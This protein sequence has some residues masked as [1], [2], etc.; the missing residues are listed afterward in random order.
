MAALLVAVLLAGPI[1][2]DLKQTYEKAVVGGD[3]KEARAAVLAM[4]DLKDARVLPFLQRE[5][6]MANEEVHQRL[7]FRA[8]A[9]TPFRD[10]EEFL[11]EHLGSPNP[12]FRATALEAIA[13]LDPD[14]ARARAAILLQL[15]DDRRVRRTAAEVLASLATPEALRTLV[16]TARD[17]SA[18]EQAMV[19]SLLRGRPT[20]QLRG[21]VPLAHHPDPEVRVVALLVLS[22]RPDF[23][24]VLEEFRDDKDPRVRLVALTGLARHAGDGRT[25]A[26]AAILAKAK[27]FDE[28]WEL[29][30]LVNRGGLQDAALTDS[31]VKAARSGLKPLRAKAA[32]AA[33]TAGGAAAVPFLKSLLAEDKPWQLPIGAARGLAATRAPEAM[34]VLIDALSKTTGRLQHE[35]SLALE[36]LT[37]QPFGLNAVVWERWWRE[38]GAG[39]QI[40]DVA[41]ALWEA[42]RSN[43]RYAFYGIEL[44]TDA[45]AFV[46]DISG[47][48]KGDRIE[49]LK[50][51][52]KI[53]VT[54]FPP[55]GKF[56]LVF[57]N[58]HAFAWAKRLVPAT[59]RNKKRALGLIQGLEANGATNIWDALGAALADKNVDTVVLLTDGMPTA[60]KDPKMRNINAIAVEFLNRNRKR[61]VL[62]HVVSIGQSSPQL[63]AMARLSGGTYTEK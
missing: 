21:V 12:Y 3:W 20:Q 38:R 56:N 30:D 18:E 33:G 32:E 5:L 39:F 45:A 25:A 51:Q 13:P 50:K 22:T 36:S 42:Q 23:Q 16:E 48:M 8:L 7:L 29:Y 2:D 43:D 11:R 15:D 63:R 61:M 10:R 40:P 31:L 60:S 57:F 44:H 17:L 53:V 35:I 4:S 1:F 27:S 19:V 37:G 9:F 41:P 34:P 24:Q 54:R 14:T 52:L 26:L 58:D 6:D 59:A 28:R 49:T 46:C 55:E 62:L 47:S